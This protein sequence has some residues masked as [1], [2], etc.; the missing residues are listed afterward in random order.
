MGVEIEEV[1]A[2]GADPITR[3]PEYVS[4]YKP[5]SNVPKDIDESKTPWQTPLLLDEITFDGLR[6][7]WVPILKLRDLDLVDHE[8]FPPLA[9]EQLMCHMI[10]T[11]MGM[12]ALEPRKWL[13]GV[14]KVG[15]LNLLWVSHYNRTPM[16][17]LVINQLLCLVHDG[18]LWLEELI[19]ITDMFIHCITCLLYTCENLAMIFGGKGGELVLT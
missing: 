2:Q 8:K 9:T 10:D 11:N 13:R 7:A 14:E 5:K 6:L 3:F 4:L 17:I 19:T 18:C 16:T 1:E 15:L 12:T